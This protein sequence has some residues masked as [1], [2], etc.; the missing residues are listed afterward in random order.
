MREIKKQTVVWKTK[1]GQ[2]KRLCDL[3]TSHLFNILKML[4]RKAVE[5]A[6]SELDSIPSFGG[7]MAQYHAE[8]S[9]NRLIDDIQSGDIVYEI[10]PIYEKVELEIK[11]RKQNG[12]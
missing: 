12:L 9:M 2:E 6:K 4:E 5:I 11:R 7:E 10:F 8:I 3:E 1:T